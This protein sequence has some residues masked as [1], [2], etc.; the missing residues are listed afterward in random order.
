MRAIWCAECARWKVTCEGVY[1]AP[2]WNGKGGGCGRATS[3]LNP[4][5]T[6]EEWT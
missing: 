4:Q 3:R 5:T 6:L 1:R 2:G